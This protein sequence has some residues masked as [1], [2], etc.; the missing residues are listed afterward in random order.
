[1]TGSFEGFSALDFDQIFFEYQ[2][3]VAGDESRFKEW[4]K[5]KKRER[6]RRL[7]VGLQSRDF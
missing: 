1:M 5:A 2:A 4:V 3:A 7:K 6:Q